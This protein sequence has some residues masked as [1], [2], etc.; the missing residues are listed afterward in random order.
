[1]EAAQ[2]FERSQFPQTL[3]SATTNLANTQ[4]NFSQSATS[5]SSS[6][7]SVD[8]AMIELQNYSKRLIKFGEQM[9]QTNQTSQEIIEAHRINQQSL[10]EMTQQLQNATQGFQL[11]MNTLDILQRR[12]VTRTESL[13]EIQSELTKLVIAIER[14]TETVRTGLDK[15]GDRLT[16][17]TLSSP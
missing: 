17:N 3:S 15:L 16:Q 4:R 9:N 8:L 12:M 13:E 2:A 5:L 6:V 7:Q 14:Y 11:A 10:A 1:M